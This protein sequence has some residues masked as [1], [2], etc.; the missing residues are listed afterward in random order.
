MAVSFGPK[1]PAAFVSTAQ[2]DTYYTAG[3]ALL[4]MLQTLVQANVISV[5]T[6]TPPGSPSNGNTYVVGSAPTG[7]W[8]THANSI[9]YWSTDNP[10]TPGGEWEFYTPATGWIVGNQTDST[11]YIFNGTAWTAVGGGGGTPTLDA[12][13]NPV[14][15]KTFDLGANSLTFSGTAGSAAITLSNAGSGGIDIDNTG[16]GGTL[17]ED[18]GGGGIDIA[19]YGGSAELLLENHGTGGTSINDTGGSGGVGGGGINM[20][21]TNSGGISVLSTGTTSFIQLN[22]TGSHGTSI[23]DSGAGGV[24]VSGTFVSLSAGAANPILLPTATG[25]AGYVLSTDGA[26]PQQLSWIA[27]GGGGGGTP[28]GANTD[29]QFNNAG[30]FGGSANLTWNN[31]TTNLTANTAGGVQFTD[32]GLTGISLF[33]T[34]ASGGGIQLTSHGA[35]INLFANTASGGTYITDEGQGIDLYA[36]AA[37]SPLTN[38]WVGLSNGTSANPTFDLNM[39][40]TGGSNGITI[41]NNCTTVGGGI[42]LNDTSGGGVTVYSTGSAGYVYVSQQGSFGTYWEDTGAGGVDFVVSG[43]NS[44]FDISNSGVGGIVIMD[45]GGGSIAIDAKGAGTPVIQLNP[46]S[47]NG[48]TINNT[49]GVS[50]GPF[51]TITSIQTTHGIV[52]TLSGTSDERLKTNIQP[53]ARGLA[54]ITAITPSTYQWNDAGQKKTGFPADVVQAGFIAQDVQKAVPEAIGQEGEYLSLDTRPILAALVNAVKELAAENKDLNT[55]LTALES[56]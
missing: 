44:F 3:E 17:I 4:R 49:P 23:T 15:S 10:A 18:H 55:R 40:G 13:L 16:T 56:K 45:T 12:V 5:A 48:L 37:S 21:A 51:T 7:A 20:E 26:N 39:R 38:I 11:A 6:N 32:S 34:A 2:G 42:F 24:S 52:T 33:S 19:S 29:I 43:T 41:E 22:N 31:S 53:F 27:P 47:S 25:T 28:G 9:A 8:A 36:S 46:G 54:A 35:G 50:A 1:I 14:A 30:A